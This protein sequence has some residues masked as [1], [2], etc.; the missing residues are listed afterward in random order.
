MP[1]ASPVIDHSIGMST[2]RAR[3]LQTSEGR[4]RLAER[5][6]AP[7]GAVVGGRRRGARGGGAHAGVFARRG[8]RGRGRGGAGGEETPAALPKLPEQRHLPFNDTIYQL[9]PDV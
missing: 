2:T 6:A 5:L 4:R 3:D 9:E 7:R 1:V 8:A